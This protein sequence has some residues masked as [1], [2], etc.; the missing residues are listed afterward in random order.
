MS[1]ESFDHILMQISADLT[2]TDTLMRESIKPNL[3]LAIT[4]HHLATGA[5]FPTIHK[6][7]RVGESTVRGIVY[8]TC[9]ALW[10]RLAP[11]YLREPQSVED[12][13][14]IS[15]GFMENWNFPNCLGAIDGRIALNTIFFDLKHNNYILIVLYL[16]V[17]NSIEK[18]KKP[19][20][21]AI[22]FW[23]CIVCMIHNMVFGL[24]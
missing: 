14:A 18:R 7:Y 6:H 10:K 17:Y 9:T 13:A 8:D 1:K 11:V 2:K 4:L 22:V 5:D 19:F 12:W 16:I 20:T 24:V 15:A 21:R 3:K 23:H